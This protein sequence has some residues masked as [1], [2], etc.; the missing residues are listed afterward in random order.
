VQNAIAPTE[1]WLKAGKKSTRCELMYEGYGQGYASQMTPFQMALVVAAGANVEGKLMKPRIELDQ[2]NE[3]FSQVLTPD[4]ARTVRGIM[5]LVTEPGGTA[6]SAMA[7]VKAAGIKSG[8]KTG[9]AQKAVPVID[10]KT[11]EPQRR[12]V[13]ERDFRGNIIRQYYEIV[14]HEKLRSDAWYLS[15]APVDRP[16]IAMAVLLEGPG[17]GISFYGGKNAG[18]IAAQ[19]LLK[20][21]SLGYF[22][23]NTSVPS[24]SPP[25]PGRRPNR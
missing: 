7:P 19:L 22:G 12:L 25:R 1:S 4:Q 2:P 11:G 10:P 9:T 21:K 16:T 6:N 14:M 8:G 24:P 15:F 18:P 17:P 13:S 3:M 23:A 5:N 20:A